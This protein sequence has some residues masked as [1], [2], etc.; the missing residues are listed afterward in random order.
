MNVVGRTLAC[1]HLSYNVTLTVSEP[2]AEVLSCSY[3]PQKACHH[4]ELGDA[5]I[6]DTD[7]N[8]VTTQYDDVEVMPNDV[9]SSP[10]SERPSCPFE[11]LLSYTLR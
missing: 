3:L 10:G 5:V 9:V 7:T 2:N 8:T 4:Q 11:R 1:L 6:L